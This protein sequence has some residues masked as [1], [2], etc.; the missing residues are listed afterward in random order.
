LAK[1]KNQSSGTGELSTIIGHDASLEG[2]LKVNAGVRNDGRINGEVY[3]S[4]I[5]TV[6][7]EGVVEGNINAKDIVIGGKVIGQLMAE[8][9]VV[10]ESKSVLEGNLKTGRLLIEEGAV[11]NGNSNMGGGTSTDTY[12]PRTINLSEDDT[13]TT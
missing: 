8:E 3:S 13:D 9:R 11:F 7:V 1:H 10:L 12:P 6:G 2:H 4:D 5:V